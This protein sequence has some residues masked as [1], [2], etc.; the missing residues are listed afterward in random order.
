MKLNMMPGRIAVKKHEMKLKGRIH[1]PPHRIKLY[2]I[3]EVVAVGAA[4]GYGPDGKQSTREV[5]TPG[6]LVL[7]QLPQAIAGRVTYDIGGVLTCFI[8]LGDILAHL[9]S[10]TL[11]LKSFQIAGRFVLL[12]PSIRSESLIIVP[13][14]A[15]QA[16]QENLHFSVAQAGRDVEYAYYAGQEVFPDKGAVNPMTIDGQERAFIEQQFICGSLGGE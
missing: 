1:L 9:T 5:Y 7:F 12:E 2:E 16:K 8:N 14:S 15:E 11:E 10:D 3:G 4:K 13:D 6:G